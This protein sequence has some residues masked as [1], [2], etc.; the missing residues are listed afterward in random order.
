MRSLWGESGYKR[1]FQ[2]MGS[3]TSA[4]N[5]KAMLGVNPTWKTSELIGSGEDVPGSMTKSD[6]AVFES[7]VSA[8]KKKCKVLL[9]DAIM[10]MG[11][12]ESTEDDA[13]DDAKKAIAKMTES[14]NMLKR[15]REKQALKFLNALRADKRNWQF[16]KPEAVQDPRDCIQVIHKVTE[17]KTNAVTYTHPVKI[18]D[19]N[20]AH[21]AYQPFI[22]PGPSTEPGTPSKDNFKETYDKF[23]E[24]PDN[25]GYAKDFM[26]NL[27]FLY[28][29][30]SKEVPEATTL[31]TGL[32]VP[33]GLK[34]ENMRRLSPDNKLPQADADGFLE[35]KFDLKNPDTTQRTSVDDI[36]GNMLPAVTGS[37]SDKQT[38]YAWGNEAVK[39]EVCTIAPQNYT[40]PALKNTKTSAFLKEILSQSS[41]RWI[42]ITLSQTAT[43]GTTTTHTLNI[44]KWSA[45]PAVRTPCK[46]YPFFGSAD[47][48]SEGTDYRD[49]KYKVKWMK[50]YTIDLLNQSTGTS[51]KILGEF[52]TMCLGLMVTQHSSVQNYIQTNPPAQNQTDPVSLADI[53]VSYTG[54]GEGDW[55][56]WCLH[57]KGYVYGVAVQYPSN[58]Y[59][60]RMQAQRGSN[61]GTAGNG[62]HRNG[63]HTGN[64]RGS[65]DSD[66]YNS[67][68]RSGSDDSGG[69]NS[70]RELYIF[71]NGKPTKTR[72]FDFWD[73]RGV[74]NGCGDKLKGYY[75]FTQTEGAA[76]NEYVYV[77]GGRTHPNKCHVYTDAYDRRAQFE[78]YDYE[79]QF[80]INGRG[81]RPWDTDFVWS[82]EDDV[83]DFENSDPATSDFS[84]DAGDVK[85]DPPWILGSYI[86]ISIETIH[87]NRKAVFR[88]EEKYGDHIIYCE[89]EY[90]SEK[91][92][93]SRFG[94]L[95]ENSNLI[96]LTAC[97]GDAID[98]FKRW[99][100]II[101]QTID[102]TK[103]RKRRGAEDA[104][105]TASF[106]SQADDVSS[107]EYDDMVKH[108]AA[109]HNANSDGSS[110]SDISSSESVKVS[111][112]LDSLPDEFEIKAED[113]SEDICPIFAAEM[114]GRYV[115]KRH[116]AA[117][118]VSNWVSYEKEPPNHYVASCIVSELQRDQVIWAFYSGADGNGVR[119]PV[120]GNG[121]TP[122]DRKQFK[123]EIRSVQVPSITGPGGYLTPW[124]VTR[125]FHLLDGPPNGAWVSGQYQKKGGNLNSKG[126]TTY[127]FQNVTNPNVFCEVNAYSVGWTIIQFHNKSITEGENIIWGQ[128]LSGSNTWLWW[129][130]DD[131][132]DESMSNI[133]NVVE[134]PGAD[135]TTAPSSDGVRDGDVRGDD[136]RDDDVTSNG[137]STSATPTSFDV[138]IT[139]KQGNP[140]IPADIVGK[141]TY[142][143]Y[144]G[145]SKIYK[146]P[147]KSIECRTKEE[148]NTNVWKFNKDGECIAIA[149]GTDIKSATWD[150]IPS[151]ISGATQKA[152][153]D[154]NRKTS[155]ASTQAYETQN[156]MAPQ[157]PNREFDN[158][159]VEINVYSRGIPTEEAQQSI[160]DTVFDTISGVY[161]LDTGKDEVHGNKFI[162]YTK[163][164]KF[165]RT[166][167]SGVKV[168][169]VRTKY[170]EK[171]TAWDIVYTKQYNYTKKKFL[172]KYAP[173]AERLYNAK[174]T[175]TDQITKMKQQISEATDGF[176]W[177][178]EEYSQPHES[179]LKNVRT[180]NVF[181]VNG[182]EH[183]QVTTD[184]MGRLP[185][186]KEARE[187]NLF[188]RLLPLQPRKLK[189]K[190]IAPYEPSR[191][192][193][194]SLVMRELANIRQA[195]NSANLHNSTARPQSAGP[196]KVFNPA[197]SSD[198]RRIRVISAETPEPHRIKVMNTNTAEPRRIRIINTQPEQPSH[199]R[200]INTQPEQPSRI[201]IINTAPAEPSRIKVLNTQPEQP[202]RIRI[203]NQET[204]EPLRIKI[205]NPG[206]SEP[207]RIKLEASSAVQP[208]LIKLSA[209][210]KQPQLI[211]LSSTPS[212]PT[213]PSTPPTLTGLVKLSAPSFPLNISNPPVKPHLNG[214][215]IPAPTP[216]S[217]GNSRGM[218]H[219]HFT[220][221][222]SA[223]APPLRH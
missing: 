221:G 123:W 128:G 88:K 10:H 120:E 22:V 65:D 62:Q 38:V 216:F 175:R 152:S 9:D 74:P 127:T 144:V 76:Q 119:L 69:Y 86:F 26:T 162:V 129:N 176:I 122:N 36:S 151:V 185:T 106:P 108:D 219:V 201:R 3:D 68:H 47:A 222:K 93:R 5:K 98:P 82:P 223:R 213:N 157:Q 217:R 34:F 116:V 45:N 148:N 43:D 104:G 174:G 169:A 21:D 77:E 145:Y 187:H 28:H 130:P 85:G 172:S 15:L 190:A 80:I 170:S 63:Y 210:S 212:Q 138:T 2:L 112:V 60:A 166:K 118:S 13:D 220:P 59:Q 124:H 7:S 100:P 95:D 52:E 37:C 204:P 139:M 137:T 101:P 126:S 113:I 79:D 211:K 167:I 84:V 89:K 30:L 218:Q 90:I 97:T 202:R 50:S 92:V 16:D 61:G 159:N 41:A 177:L 158:A 51:K 96:E 54:K 155:A 178:A 141:F 78:F 99:P 57:L 179:R 109:Q 8:M 75:Y 83:A 154:V 49:S 39:L 180:W 35:Y 182:T 191:D 196:I 205:L 136:V 107:D 198:P 40:M 214:R 56:V 70:W 200:I 114:V 27:H 111:E 207:A 53:H 131:Q 164:E 171:K 132:T 142:Y 72:G 42:C 117:I 184:V 67:W 143:S 71:E 105:D 160:A 189:S 32:N 163:T 186:E 134:E 4:V 147:N 206:T 1:P 125:S 91:D 149:R 48:G 87:N 133:E 55:S 44:N 11:L 208:K 173:I 181:T 29:N 6:K 20:T 66:G 197:S 194:L 46:V 193:G 146:H 110:S 64:R 195:L 153:S 31:Y 199:I 103:T 33:S 19:R 94:Y 183:E 150:K 12:M 14:Q 102:F 165:S 115:N 73:V 18:Y 192:Q 188:K 203:L 121:K 81:E 17:I 24:N 135:Q 156:T 25:L 58:P 168:F 23:I 140:N 209:N 215:I 161:S